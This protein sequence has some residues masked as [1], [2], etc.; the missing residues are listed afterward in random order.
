[1][2]AVMVYLLVGMMYI[3]APQRLLTLSTA[4]PS[5]ANTPATV[6]SAGAYTLVVPM[7]ATVSPTLM[8]PPARRLKLLTVPPKGAVTLTASPA[9]TVPSKVVSARAMKGS[10]VRNMARARNRFITGITSLLLL[11]RAGLSNRRR[12]VVW[13]QAGHILRRASMGLSLLAFLAG[14]Q[15]K[16][17]PTAAE[18]PTPRPMAP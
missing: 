12:H 16:M 14:D 15:P 7:A 6:P 1:M 2:S 3:T 10:R 13:E 18:K 9:T 11:F 8:S 5:W 4:S 17:M